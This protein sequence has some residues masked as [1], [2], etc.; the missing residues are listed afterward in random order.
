VLC[1]LSKDHDKR[2]EH[3]E[4]AITSHNYAITL[5]PKNSMYL[6]T[7]GHSLCVMA[8]IHSNNKEHDEALIFYNQAIS[9]FDQA[10]KLDSENKEYRHDQARCI[11]Q[12]GALHF[13]LGMIRLDQQKYEEAIESFKEAITLYDKAVKLDSENKE[14]RHDQAHCCNLVGAFRLRLGK[15]HLDQ[16][17][18][19][20]AIESF[21]EAITLYDKAVKLGG[22]KEAFLNL[23]IKISHAIDNAFL[24]QV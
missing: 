10:I 3:F 1:D 9:A 8:K 18:Y 20:E 19:E 5:A 4:K 11:E 15:I 12:M 17:K 7:K 24:T 23:Q 16:Q 2:N 21:K 14:Y 13:S 6:N 22:K